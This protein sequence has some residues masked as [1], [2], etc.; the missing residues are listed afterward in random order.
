M[1]KW[2]V[3]DTIE[4]IWIGDEKGPILY[5]NDPERPML[6]GEFMAKV[7]CSM[8]AIRLGHSPTRYRPKEWVEQP[9]RLKDSVDTKMSTLEA[10]ERY[11]KG[12]L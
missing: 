11:E 1:S 5:D 4:N 12:H 7:S 9:V 10:L 8:V 2:G 3:Y 6:T